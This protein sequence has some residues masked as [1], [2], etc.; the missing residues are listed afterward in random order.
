MNSQASLQQDLR[1]MGIRPPDT[2]LI[3]SS[4]KA[5]GPTEGGPQGVLDALSG[6][7]APGLL[8]FP[9]LSWQTADMPEPAFDLR[10]TPSI[11]GLLPELFRQR[12]GVCRGANPTH[13][14]SALG[15]D[16]EGFV[17]EDHLDGTPCGPRSSWR[18][19]V[20]RD[21]FILMAGCDLRQCTFIHGVEEWCAVPRRL[22]RPKAYR[23][24]LADG[25]VRMQMH[26]AHGANPSVNYW[27]IEEA[28]AG[29]GLLSYH[30]LGGARTLVTRARDLYTFTAGCL[31]REPGLFDNPEDGVQ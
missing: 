26:A 13:S 6:Y 20:A 21:A 11:V 29:A 25:S 17:A 18:K 30:R 19:L 7:L 27:L 16:A 9:T 1:A 15:A 22:G 31:S 24:T 5:I 2:V 28:L 10:Q 23:V 4:M 3:H 12:P 14:I 8:C